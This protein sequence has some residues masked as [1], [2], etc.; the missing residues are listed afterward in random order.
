MDRVRDGIIPE[1]LFE[2]CIGKYSDDY[3]RRASVVSRSCEMVSQEKDF[4]VITL[5]TL[6]RASIRKI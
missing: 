1:Q 5:L 2:D 4:T 6:G 3:G